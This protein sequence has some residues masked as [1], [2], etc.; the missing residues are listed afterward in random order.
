MSSL[1]CSRGS[2]GAAQMNQTSRHILAVV[3]DGGA[4]GPTVVVDQGQVGK[5]TH[6]DSLQTSLVAQRESVTL[7]L[8][9]TDVQ[10]LHILTIELL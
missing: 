5:E 8:Q 4:V 9:R 10:V 3:E 7:D 6:A 1:P 2:R